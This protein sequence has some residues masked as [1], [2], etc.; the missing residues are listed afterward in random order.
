MSEHQ[1]RLKGRVWLPGKPCLAAA[2][3]GPTTNSWFE[4][5]DGSGDWQ[6]GG[7]DLVVLS[8]QG[9][10]RNDRAGRHSRPSATAS[11]AARTTGPNRILSNWPATSAI[12]GAVLINV[13]PGP[14]GMV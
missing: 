13:T 12:T 1:V 3:G 5:T 11:T 14:T 4:G 10:L 2:D 6:W 9:Q 7:V 8:L